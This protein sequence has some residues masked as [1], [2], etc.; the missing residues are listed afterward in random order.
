MAT[1]IPQIAVAFL[2]LQSFISKKDHYRRLD[3]SGLFI[4][5]RLTPIWLF[6]ALDSYLAIGRDLWEKFINLSHILMAVTQYS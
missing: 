4:N 6:N 5:K 1:A 3:N 2:F